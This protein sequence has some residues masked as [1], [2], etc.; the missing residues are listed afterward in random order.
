MESRT[1]LIK[2]ILPKIQIDNTKS[3][4]IESFQS[5]T[6]RPILK[7]QNELILKYF[8]V[9]CSENKIEIER[10]NTQLKLAK[11]S[12][13]LKNSIQFKTF[14]LGLIVAFFSE[15]EFDFYCLNKREINKRIIVLLIERIYSQK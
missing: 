14:L 4:A 5:D 8:N 9:F 12:D 15:E 13:I 10:L 1:N 7:F 6:L 11:I 2:S 3:L